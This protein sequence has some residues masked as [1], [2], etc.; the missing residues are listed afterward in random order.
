MSGGK[1]A[2]SE[3]GSVM[4]DSIGST[5][6][7]G[8]A[9]NTDNLTV[10]VAYGLKRSSIR[11][12]HNLLIAAATTTITLMALGVGRQ[13]A[14]CCQWICPGTIGGIL[15]IS[16]AVWGTYREQIEAASWPGKPIT[17]TS[18]RMPVA[19]SEVLFLAGTLS[20]NNIGLAIAGGI[21]GV[22]YTAAGAFTFSFS[23]IMLALGQ[24]VGTNFT[25]LR[26]LGQV[27]RYPMIGNGALALAGTFMLTGY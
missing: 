8:L 20:I 24:V 26:S 18:P 9:A 19:L 13:F 12:G 14:W 10:G 16:L 21:G 2:T 25:R 23:V 11:W 27:L 5:L 15:L 6:L 17:I 7:F 22:R 3:L 4:L 1:S